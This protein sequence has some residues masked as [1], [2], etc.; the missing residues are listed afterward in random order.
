MD[1]ITIQAHQAEKIHIGDKILCW[2]TGQ[3]IG[4]DETIKLE[5]RPLAFL[6]YFCQHPQQPISREQLLEFVWDNR[7][8]SDDAIR[9]VVKKLRE[10]LGDNAKSPSYIKT[11]PL[12]GYMLIA[13]IRP[14]DAKPTITGSVI[15]HWQNKHTFITL[16]S[17]LISTLILWLTLYQTNDTAEVPLIKIEKLT[18]LSGSEGDGSFNEPLQTLIFSHR[19]SI[20]SAYALY[21]KHLPSSKVERLTFEDAG[22]YHP[23]FS[24]DSSLVSYIRETNDGLENVIANYSTEGLTHE[25]VIVDNG[26]KK[27]VLSWSADGQSLYFRSSQFERSRQESTA[28]YRYMLSNRQW[29]QVTFPH[30]KGSGDQLAEES[31]DGRYLAIIRNTSDRRFSLLIL[32]LLNKQII[33]EQ[34][35][36]FLAQKIMWLDKQADRLAISGFNGQLYYFDIELK[37]LTHQEG[38]TSQLNEMF[39]DCGEHCFYMR[40]AKLNVFDISE[41]PNPFNK[42]IKLASTYFESKHSELYPVYNN[43]G[44]SVYFIRKD[45]N[46]VHMMRHTP[47]ITEEKLFSVNS[48]NNISQ[49]SIHPDEVYIA[50]KIEGRVFTYN[51]QNQ[52]LLFI[53]SQEELIS[54]SGWSRDGQFLYFSRLDSPNTVLL[55]YDIEAKEIIAQQADNKGYFELTDGRDFIIDKNNNLLQQINQKKQKLIVNLPRSGLG[56]WQIHNE[57]LYYIEI[58][59][60]TVYINQHNLTTGK[61]IRKTLFENESVAIFS[62]HPSGHKMLITK[63]L[64]DEGDLV[65]VQLKK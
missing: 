9:G 25:T 3:L 53:T 13:A 6:Y 4:K 65:K 26:S 5:P 14:V 32:D 27:E 12:K 56:N 7:F 44:N 2:R 47:E 36:P 19:K 38:L 20:H 59:G 35:L 24:P 33:I 21:R 15:R 29:Q 54:M 23:R 63:S 51:L 49:L 31:R 50:G 43:T 55:K 60:P 64:S 17:V 40:Q 46:G 1:N 58:K 45:E 57:F 48:N 18:K 62:L 22:H 8:V 16:F 37:T 41:I 11:I 42:R 30:V 39:Y 52:Q 28:I 61:N 34:P 10:A